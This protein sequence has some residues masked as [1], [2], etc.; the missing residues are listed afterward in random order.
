MRYNVYT[1]EEVK[2]KRCFRAVHECLGAQCMAWQWQSKY[3]EEC[4][5]LTPEFGWCGLV[6]IG[7]K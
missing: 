6:H 5:A 4:K 1:E 3:D 7:C 2:E